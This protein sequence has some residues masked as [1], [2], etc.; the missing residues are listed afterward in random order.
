MS[1]E[2]ASLPSPAKPP[3]SASALASRSPRKSLCPS[4]FP[5]SWCCGLEATSGV[6][7]KGEI[8]YNPEDDSRALVR[9]LDSAQNEARDIVAKAR[10]RRRE[11][12]RRCEKEAEEETHHFMDETQRNFEI[13]RVKTKS[14]MM[15][16]AQLH[17]TRAEQDVEAMRRE[18]PARQHTAVSFAISAV[19]SVK[20]E[21]PAPAREQLRRQV[22]AAQAEKERRLRQTGCFGMRR[23][24][25]PR[26]N[27]K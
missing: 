7:D 4:F 24:K 5:F 2:E 9:M 26:G 17:D 11:L 21:L 16:D 6:V 27:P 8:V 22:Q 23:P 15:D 19:T 18:A 3:A 20:L 13:F 12:M 25:R 14:H 1:E 10:Q